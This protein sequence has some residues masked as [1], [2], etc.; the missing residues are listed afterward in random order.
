MAL[1]LF[2][3]F[4]FAHRFRRDAVTCL[5]FRFFASSLE[6]VFGKP[7]LALCCVLA[8]PSLG[9]CGEDI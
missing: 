6:I 2:F 3:Y 8:R 4:V 5:I 1:P 7:L 9:W